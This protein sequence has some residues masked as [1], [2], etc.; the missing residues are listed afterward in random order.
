MLNTGTQGKWPYWRGVLILEILKGKCTDCPSW[1]VCFVGI[2]PGSGLER[3]HV[4]I[5]LCTI[6]S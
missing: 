1:P 3:E 2:L 5:I 6:S 4:N